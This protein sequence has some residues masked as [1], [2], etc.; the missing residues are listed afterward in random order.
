MRGAIDKRGSKR[1]HDLSQLGT[2]VLVEQMIFWGVYIEELFII[3]CK[4]KW[5]TDFVVCV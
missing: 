5:R 2:L 1:I 4:I 3:R